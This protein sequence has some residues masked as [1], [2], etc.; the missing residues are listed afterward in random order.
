MRDLPLYEKALR[1]YSFLVE[2][3][4]WY[5][6]QRRNKSKSCSGKRNSKKNPDSG[7]RS[8]KWQLM[9]CMTFSIKDLTHCINK[10]ELGQL[11]ASQKINRIPGI[12]GFLWNKEAF[13][14][15]VMKGKQLSASLRQQS[16]PLC[17][18]L[19]EQRQQFQEVAQAFGPSTQW[20][21]KSVSSVDRSGPKQLDI[22]SPEGQ[23]ELE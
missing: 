9:L 11:S 14:S 22:F 23:K 8:N 3:P 7:F 4:S 12:R 18:S 10:K 17:F 21:L 15:T 13:C 20:F 16:V 19:P 1:N 6:E 2:R 5:V